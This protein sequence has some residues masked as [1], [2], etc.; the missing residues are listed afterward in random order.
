MNEEIYRMIQHECQGRAQLV[1]VS[2]KRSPA[3]IMAYYQLGVRDFG[4]NRVQELIEKAQVLPSDIRWH[5]IGHLQRNK[6]RQLIPYVSMIHSVESL[7]LIE[8]LEKEAAQINRSIPVLIQFNL[9]EE[10]TKSGL[11]LQEADSFFEK[12]LPLQHIEVR[13]IM[14]IGPHTDDMAKIDECFQKGAELLHTLQ[15]K[16]PSLKLTELSMGMSQDWPLALKNGATLLRIGTILFEM[17]ENG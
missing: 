8:V 4:E 2:K 14:L 10:A 3:E 1:V 6:V 12:L 9:A 15:A 7:S 13:G 11:F 17:P 16:W 5:F